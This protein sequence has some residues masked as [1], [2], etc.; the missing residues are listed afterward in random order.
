MR[1]SRL[2]VGIFFLAGLALLGLMVWQVGLSDLLESFRAVGFWLLPF[3]LLES[4]P[5]LVHT[6]AWAACF[7]TGQQSVGLWQLSLVRLAG[8][9]IN[10][11]TPTA[12]IGG[13]VVKVLLL[14]PV[15]RHEQA[16]ASVV[17]DKASYTLAQIGYLALG[18]LYVT[19]R[20]PLPAEL[21]W[22]LACTLSLIFVGLI[23]F[24]LFQR[25]GL[26]SRCLYHLERLPIGRARLQR[27][28]PSIVALE[29]QFAAYY[30][31][32]R[33]RFMAS[34]GLHGL[35]FVL[36]SIQT[37]CLLK[38]LLA[39]QAPSLT[40][41]LAVSVVVMA[42]DQAFFFVPGSLGTLEGVRFTVLSTLGVAQVY[43][44]AFGLIIRLQQLF[45]NGVGLLAYAWCSRA[46]PPVRG[47]SPATSPLPPTIT[48]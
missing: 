6:L 19:S 25:Y 12:T 9:T 35:A 14:A 28:Q 13:E 18:T 27:L 1:V 26:L 2:C 42:L 37:W 20:L 47:A 23:G 10:Q 29:A 21:Q 31:A 34:L 46:A 5:M 43:G 8:S 33:W 7:S 44:L 45:W 32:H 24:I 15:V 48:R 22:G 30:T 11:V 17:I 4:L 16:T 41:A 38:L 36:G 40:D 3:I 39:S